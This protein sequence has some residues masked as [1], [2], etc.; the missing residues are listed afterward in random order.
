MLYSP[1]EILLIALVM[2]F[3]SV[4]QGAIGFASGLLGVP[5]LV[6]FG[7]SLPEAAIINL[8]ST[9]VQ[10]FTGTWKL[11][12]YL[13]VR[14]LIYPTVIRLFAIPLG[15]ASVYWVNE[16]ITQAQSKQL[17]G[18]LML[19]VVSLLWLFK[20]ERRDYLNYFWQTLAFFSSG[21]LLGFASIGGAPLVIYVNSLTWRVNK[22]RAF[23]F[24]CSAIGQP[25]AIWF[26]WRQFS[27]IFWTPVCSTFVI[28][29]AIFAGLW[30]GLPLGSRL[31]QPVFRTITLGLILMTALAA[32]VSPYLSN[33]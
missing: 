16:R 1:Y 14:E 23:L 6:I 29:P 25:L 15:T 26:F 9:S 3:G 4:V 20:V 5:L 2:S 17:V 10:N 18:G 21:F 22:S 32:I 31:S 19:L 8:I 30:I 7:F 11:W 24:F 33:A 28:L 12:D 27:G 13:D